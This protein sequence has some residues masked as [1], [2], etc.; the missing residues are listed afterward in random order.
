[1]IPQP[2]HGLV[3]MLV[4]DTVMEQREYKTVKERRLIIRAFEH[5][6]A[7]AVQVMPKVNQTRINTEQEKELRR[8][9]DN[10][11]HYC[12]YTRNTK[13]Q[14]PVS[15]DRYRKDYKRLYT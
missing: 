13:M 15:F 14:E 5:L 1:M 2:Q 7:D 11:Y 9:E 6:G 8:M 10:Y 12:R 4:G 3:K